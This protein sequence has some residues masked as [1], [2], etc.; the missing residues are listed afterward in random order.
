MTGQDGGGAPATVVLGEVVGAHGVRGEVKVYS[1]TRPRENIFDYPVWTLE[2]EAGGRDYAL[3][4][5]RAQG[6][7][8]VAR[9]A[10]VEDRETAQAL[11]G[12]AIRVPRTALP[13]LAPG[14]YYWADL[15]GL[16][17]ITREGVELGQVADLLE[18]GAN[19]VLVVRGE[20]ERLIPYVPGEVVL[21]VDVAAGWLQVDWDPEF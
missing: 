5:G 19:D 21:E 1:A 3:V 18:T 17:V 15:Q 9:L 8:L 7:G 13:P 10:G 16:R 4:S 6:K 14:E 12:S 11:R 2:T 20:R